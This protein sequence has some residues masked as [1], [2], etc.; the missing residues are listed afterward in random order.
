MSKI[1]FS[2]EEKELI[3]SKIQHY[4]S[5]ELD[6]EIGRFDAEFFLDFLSKELGPYFY[7]RG[8][9]DA[10]SVVK[11]RLESINDAIYEIEKPTDFIR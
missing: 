7:N 10:Q 5:E 9:F 6:Q 3:I 1:E 2:K 11:E 8:L 4:F